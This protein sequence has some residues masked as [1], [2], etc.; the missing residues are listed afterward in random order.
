VRLRIQLTG[1]PDHL[2]RQ[3]SR[4]D[5]HPSSTGTPFRR[6]TLDP[7]LTPPTASLTIHSHAR[8]PLSPLVLRMIC[9]TRSC[10]AAPT[11]DA[12]R[13]PRCPFTR[14]SPRHPGPPFPS[15]SDPVHPVALCRRVRSDDRGL[16][17]QADDNRRRDRAARRPRHGRPGGVRVRR[18]RLLAEHLTRRRL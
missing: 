4:T 14:Q 15:H 2:H 7:A 13:A 8:P 18:L 9:R 6:S 10:T 16:V 11:D 1:L 17:P 3:D 12:R 5:Y